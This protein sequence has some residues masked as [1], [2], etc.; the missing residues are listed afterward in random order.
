MGF[1][2]AATTALLLRGDEPAEGIAAR[3][4]AVARRPPRYG[5]TGTRPR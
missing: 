3:L 1:V 5:A 4:A 2:F